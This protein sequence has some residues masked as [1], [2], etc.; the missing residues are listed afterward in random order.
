MARMIPIWFRALMDSRF[1]PDQQGRY[2]VKDLHTHPQIPVTDMASMIPIWFRALMDSRFA[3]IN[4]VDTTSKIFIL[5]TP[6]TGHRHG[7]N[8]PMA[9]LMV[10]SVAVPQRAS[11]MLK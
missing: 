4:R 2:N 8:D 9:A 7:E 11:P 6:D 10:S 5:S 3:P 1:C